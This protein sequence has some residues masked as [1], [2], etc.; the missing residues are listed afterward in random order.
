MALYGQVGQQVSYQW[1]GPRD[2]HVMTNTNDVDLRL[3]LAVVLVVALGALVAPFL[4]ALVAGVFLLRVAAFVLLS[5]VSET[6][7]GGLADAILFL[8]L[9]FVVSLVEFV[10]LADCLRRLDVP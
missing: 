1:A 2:I 8:S 4:V 9:A 7:A 10:L 6:R 3:T 5:L